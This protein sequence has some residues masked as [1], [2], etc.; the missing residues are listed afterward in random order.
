MLG[1]V[2]PAEEQ[3][4]KVGEI[5]TVLTGIPVQTP[6]PQ[7]GNADETLN[8]VASVEEPVT[9]AEGTGTVLVKAPDGNPVPSFRHTDEAL[10]PIPSLEELLRVEPPATVLMK[11]AEAAEPPATDQIPSSA[12]IVRA[13]SPGFPDATVNWAAPPEPP[14]RPMWPR[15]A[16]GL[17]D[18]LE[19]PLSAA[20]K[21]PASRYMVYIGVA[22]FAVICLAVLGTYSWRGASTKPSGQSGQES[23]NQSLPGAGTST[24][25]APQAAGAPPGPA[26][27]RSTAAGT[28]SV[29]ASDA[30]LSPSN[31]S[32]ILGEPE[33]LARIKDLLSQGRALSDNGEYT[34]A[35]EM[36]DSALKLDPQS[37]EAKAGKRRAKERMQLEQALTGESK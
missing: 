14:R 28:H 1:A 26:T 31:S 29:S 18:T 17:R 21:A 20:R 22:V 11:A 13:E 16:P 2:L 9:G 12:D 33:R 5:G 8:P 15:E 4:K 6:E 24:Q 35:I 37:S 34:A 30:A 19:A 23:Q 10:I 25:P 36:F 3:V 32:A 7:P 27:Q